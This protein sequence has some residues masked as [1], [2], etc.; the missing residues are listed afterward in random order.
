MKTEFFGKG[1]SNDDLIV[2]CC[3]YLHEKLHMRV[4][5]VSADYNLS[6]KIAEQG[7]W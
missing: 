4:I 1:T 2:D 7:E 6:T 3:L 5:S